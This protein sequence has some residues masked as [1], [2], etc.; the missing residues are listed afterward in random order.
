MSLMQDLSLSN[1]SCAPLMP[2]VGRFL[3]I[4]LGIIMNMKQWIVLLAGVVLFLLSEL[5]PPW[6]YTD[7]ITSARRSAGYHFLTASPEVDS[8]AEMKRVFSF[9]NEEPDRPISISKDG[10]RLNGQRVI[11][12]FSTLGLLLV[13]YDPRAKLRLIFGSLSLCIALGFLTLYL[14]TF[15]PFS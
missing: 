10:A 6:V 1:G 3:D 11:L 8:P 5:C 7:G 2:S 12:L 13:L 9:A 14:F 15:R 4:W